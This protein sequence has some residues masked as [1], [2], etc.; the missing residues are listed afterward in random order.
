M[1]YFKEVEF[2]GF[3]GTNIRANSWAKIY[4]RKIFENDRFAE[5]NPRELREKIVC[6]NLFS[7]VVSD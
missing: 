1:S 7:Y 3:R 5:I 2:S 4:P 6:E